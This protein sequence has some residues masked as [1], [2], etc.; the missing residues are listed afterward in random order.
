[1][2]GPRKTKVNAFR[3]LVEVEKHDDA[4][5]FAEALGA[6]KRLTLFQDERVTDKAVGSG[7]KKR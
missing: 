4:R 3:Q 1:M 2:P 7:L 6:R 5:H